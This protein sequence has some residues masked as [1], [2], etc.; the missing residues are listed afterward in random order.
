L[1]FILNLPP[2]GIVSSSLQNQSAKA[3]SGEFQ[4]PFR[5]F[6]GSLLEGVKHVDALR[7]LCKV[8]DSMCETGVDTN[9]PNTGSDRGHRLPVVRFKPLLDTPK[10]KPRD[11]AGVSR[12]SFEIVPGRSEPKQ[13]LV[14]HGSICKYWYTL[15]SLKLNEVA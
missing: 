7:K 8:E 14:R 15:S 10:L 6:P 12:K 3:V 2:R 5:G 9:L 1:S 4:V 11:A 13:R